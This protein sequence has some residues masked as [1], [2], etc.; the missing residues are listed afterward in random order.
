MPY[1]SDFGSSEARPD[2]FTPVS[3]VSMSSDSPAP[4]WKKLTIDPALFK[5][6]PDESAFLKAQTGIQDD[7]KL[8]EHVLAVQEEAWKVRLPSSEPQSRNSMECYIGLPISLYPTLYIHKVRAF[9]R[10]AL[11]Q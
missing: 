10:P 6:T 3:S 2:H 5:P 7:G 8:K 9:H 1:A 11:S 4:E